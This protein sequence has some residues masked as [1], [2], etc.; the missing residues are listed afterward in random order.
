MG[1]G[2]TTIGKRL[3]KSLGRKFVDTDREI[4]K[5]TGASVSLIFDIEGESGFRERE[6]RLIDELTSETGLVLAT[7]GGAVL[8][9]ENRNNLRQRG[10]VIYLSATP[11]LLFDRMTYDHSRPLLQ[12]DDRMGRILSLLET[13]EPYYRQTADL[14]LAVD[15]LTAG[16]IV[17]QISRHVDGLC[18]K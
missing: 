14:T 11:E 8:L 5:R 16:Q 13:R 6:S 2:K 4:E 7:G 1:V 3:A 9:P 12:T 17:N 10:M 18:V 15:N